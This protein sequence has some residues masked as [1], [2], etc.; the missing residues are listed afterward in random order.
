MISSSV[1]AIVPVA[2]VLVLSSCAW[3]SFK[4]QMTKWSSNNYD[5]SLVICFPIQYNK[6]ELP[7]GSMSTK[8]NP[9]NR[10]VYALHFDKGFVIFYML[11]EV[12]IIR[13]RF[14]FSSIIK[15]TLPFYC[16]DIRVLEFGCI[17]LVW[18]SLIHIVHNKKR[19]FG[20][21]YTRRMVS[22]SFWQI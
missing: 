2:S 10:A 17:R 20:V 6:I 3:L 14:P 5:C 19:Y 12:D 22:L 13:N 18:V 1:A 9:M 15:M 4:L 21:V 16:N 11:W 7:P 8:G